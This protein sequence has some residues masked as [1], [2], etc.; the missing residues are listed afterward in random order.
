MIFTSYSST[1]LKVSDKAFLTKK[2]K[3]GGITLLTSV[4][5][6]QIK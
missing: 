2:N 6:I 3:T 4:Y 5:T 1:I